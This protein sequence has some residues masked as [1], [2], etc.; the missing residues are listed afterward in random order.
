MPFKDYLKNCLT[1][2]KKQ[3]T[4]L[5]RK[6]KQE[7]EKVEAL[8]FLKRTTIVCC[9]QHCLNCL[10]QQLLLKGNKILPKCLIKKLTH[11]QVLKFK[12]K[13]MSICKREASAILISIF[14]N[15]PLFL[16]ALW[17][18]AL[19]LAVFFDTSCNFVWPTFETFGWLTPLN[20][21]TQVQV[22]KI[23]SC[24]SHEKFVAV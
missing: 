23:S 15:F 14:V 3:S 11:E 24:T 21:V 18:L 2:K 20:V 5:D 19:Y 13:T 8:T 17:Q 7:R 16:K 4:K 22:R 9:Y 12:K 1:S 6:K 10:R